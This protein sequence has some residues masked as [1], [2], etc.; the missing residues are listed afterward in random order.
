MK[1]IIG[2]ILCLCMSPVFGQAQDKSSRQAPLIVKPDKFDEW[3]D[4]RFNDEKARLDKIAVQAKEWSLSI[5]YLSIHAGRTACVGE[6]KARGVRAKNHLINRGISSNRIVW[7]DAGW[8]E[9]VTVEVWIWPPEM[10][11]P[12]PLPDLNL[13]PSEVKLQKNCRIKYRGD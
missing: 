10:G 4:I 3:G 6:A 1:S 5:I 12:S 2:I 11:K 8:A 13:K 7:I 9:N